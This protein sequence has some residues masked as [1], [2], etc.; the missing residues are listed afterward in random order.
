MLDPLVVARYRSP[1][2]ESLGRLLCQANDGGQ[3][4]ELQRI[5]VVPSHPAVDLVDDVIAG[6]WIGSDEGVEINSDVAAEAE[7]LKPG[8]PPARRRIVLRMASLA[9]IVPDNAGNRTGTPTPP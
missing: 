8:I 6:A 2:N 4:H 5:P 7:Q 3:V 1:T 9:R